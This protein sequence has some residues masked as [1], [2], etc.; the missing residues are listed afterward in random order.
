[1]CAITPGLPQD[2]CIASIMIVPKLESMPV[3]ITIGRG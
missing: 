3:L 1:L 2:A